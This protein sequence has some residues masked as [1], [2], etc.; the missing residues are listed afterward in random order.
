VQRHKAGLIL[1]RTSRVYA[2]PT[3]VNPRVLEN[4]GAFALNPSKPLLAGVSA[5]GVTEKFS[6]A[7]PLSLLYGASKLASELLALEYGEAFGLPTW[8]NRCGVLAGGAI[9]TRRPRHC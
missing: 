9:R 2:T 8:I 3:P 7:P 1:L 5:Q 6:T 4:N